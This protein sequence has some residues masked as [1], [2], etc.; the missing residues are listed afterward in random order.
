M[1]T[2]NHCNQAIEEGAKISETPCCGIKMH[3]ACAIQRIAEEIHYYCTCTCACGTQLYGFHQNYSEELS[4]E[5]I[6]SHL[7]TI[8]EKPGVTEELKL[9]KKG[10]SEENKAYVAYNRFL[11]GKQRELKE[12]VETHINAIKNSKTTIVNTVKQSEEYK[13][14]R[15]IKSRRT[16]LQNKFKAKHNVS[17]SDMRGLLGFTRYSSWF[18]YRYSTPSGLMRRKFRIKL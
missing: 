6:T 16:L 10:F 12:A 18:R 11:I 14:L 2:C 5:Q 9:L 8:R 3:A 7:N 4:Q 15:N 1:S 13:N 17:N